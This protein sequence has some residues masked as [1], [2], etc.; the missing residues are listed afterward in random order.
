MDES[1]VAGLLTDESVWHLQIELMRFLESNWNE[2]DEGIWEL[3]GARKDFTHSKMMAWVAFDRAIK[4][5]ET[6][7]HSAGRHVERWKIMRQRIHGEVCEKGYNTSK[8]AFTQFYGS[9]ALDA[10]LLMMPRV[11]FLPSSDERVRG[12]IEAIQRELV[13]D[14]LVLRYRPDRGVE[15]LPG[16]EGT[17]LPCSF[18]L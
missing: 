7:E 18:W 2:P 13:Q 17:F 1:H 8:K 9:N 16:R 14:G 15:G 12:T 6:C 5:S 11:G 10:S 3:R 4:L